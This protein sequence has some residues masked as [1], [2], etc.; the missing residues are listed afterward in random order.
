MT[1]VNDASLDEQAEH[2]LGTFDRHLRFAQIAGE[3][4]HQGQAQ[5][6]PIFRRVHFRRQHDRR[7][8]VEPHR[9]AMIGRPSPITR[10]GKQHQQQRQ[11]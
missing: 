10:C 1:S 8:L 3:Q 7:A 11:P 9:L 2:G 6:F 5:P 4:I